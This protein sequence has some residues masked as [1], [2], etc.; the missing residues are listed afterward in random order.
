MKKNNTNLIRK[1][2][3][4]SAL[5]VSFVAGAE[6]ANGQ[7]VYTDIVPDTLLSHSGEAYSIDLNHDGVVDL[8]IKIRITLTHSSSG[9]YVHAMEISANPGAYDSLAGTTSHRY[10]NNWAFPAKLDSG[11][12]I[13][14]DLSGELSWNNRSF[15]TAAFWSQSIG[16]YGKW[17]NTADKYIALRFLKDQSY[18][19]GWL[20][21]TTVLNPPFTVSAVLKDFAYQ[22]LGDSSIVAGDTGTTNCSKPSNLS[23]G[24]ITYTSANLKWDAVPD[25][26]KYKVRYEIA[27]TNDWTTLYPVAHH[28]VITDLLPDTKYTWQVKTLCTTDSPS[29]SSVWSP[30]QHFTTLVRL[31]DESGLQTAFQLYPNPAQGYT[32]IQF[33]LVQPS[34]VSVIVCDMSGK[35]IETILNDLLEEGN[36]SLQL[37][38]SKFSKG[39]YVVRMISDF[40][41]ENTKLIVQ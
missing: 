17:R 15:Q 39:M 4:Y 19:Y 38:T 32:S 10:G 11:A 23:T 35:E 20:R 41:I 28:K 8:T 24:N 29:E 40:G 14:K 18:Y 7:V 1:L 37:N 22:S 21:M 33:K 6:I 31:G 5:A 34:N 36:H 27:G 26:E 9:T 13:G 2:N 25:A 16:S 12:V 30:K 3:S